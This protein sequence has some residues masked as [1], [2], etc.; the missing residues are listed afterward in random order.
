PPDYPLRLLSLIRGNAIHSQMLP[1]DQTSLPAAWV[2]PECAALGQIDRS[3]SVYLVSPLGRLRVDL[4]LR[5]GL[6]P[7]CVLYR[8]GDWMGLGGGVNQLIHEETTDMGSG[9]PYYRQYIRLEN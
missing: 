8:R 1:Q 3:R 6:H 7:Q 5:P 4:K 9:T 2:A